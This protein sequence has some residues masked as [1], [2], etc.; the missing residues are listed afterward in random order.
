MQIGHSRI[1]T[2]TTNDSL[3]LRGNETISLPFGGIPLTTSTAMS[4]STRNCTDADKATSTSSPTDTTPHDGRNR[5][6]FWGKRE[7]ESRLRR[8]GLRIICRHRHI[9]IWLRLLGG[10]VDIGLEDRWVNLWHDDILVRVWRA[11]MLTH[12]W[13]TKNDTKRKHTPGLLPS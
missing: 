7:W 8:I 9:R 6:K 2:M 12:H 13:H 1:L 4:S 11:E 5:C 3:I 10:S